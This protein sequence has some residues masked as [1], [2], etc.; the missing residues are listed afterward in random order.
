M[1]EKT[2]RIAVLAV[3]SALISGCATPPPLDTSSVPTE[4][5]SAS[6]APQPRT[7]GIEQA[8]LEKA[9][10][11]MRER[12]WA[13]AL[14]QWELL[15]LLNPSAGNYRDE[16]GKLRKRIRDIAADLLNAAEKARR[17]GNLEQATLGYL[18]VLNVD[19][20]NVA[21]EQALR[22][23]DKERVRRLYLNRP[24]RMAM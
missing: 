17:Q 19:R 8:Y 5:P 21:A 12:R 10:L 11:L 1:T 24:P 14:V 15:A 7:T 23:I 3:L 9:Q 22:Q 4:M 2:A 18:R 13:D 6:V 20:D 16:I